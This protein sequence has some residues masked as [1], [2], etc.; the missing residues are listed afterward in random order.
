MTIGVSGVDA[1]PHR[2]YAWFAVF[3]FFLAATLSY[4]DRLILNLMVD[5]IRADLHISDTGISLLQGVAFAALYACLGLPLGRYA[6][7]HNRRNLVIAGVAVWSICT[8]LCGLAQSFGQ[9]FLVRVGVG[10]GEAALAPAAISMIADYFPPHR[11]GTAISLFLAGMVAGAGAANIIGG[12]LL[13][14]IGDGLL[15]H[16][17]GLAG[18]APWRAVFLILSVPGLLI[19]ALML[20]VREPR[21]RDRLSDAGAASI[22]TVVDY[23]RL[24]RRTFGL[25]L[26]AFALLQVVDY[27]INSWFPAHLMRRFAWTPVEV[28]TTLGVIGISCGL[29]GALAGG[30]LVDFVQSRGYIDAKVRVVTI[31]TTL[32]LPALLFPLLP[33]ATSAIALFVGYTLVMS[34]MGAAGIGAVQD[35]APSDMRGL[36]V[37]L[38]AFIY[39]LLGLGAGPT[40]VALT[41]DHILRD[42]AKVGVSIVLVA[43]PAAAIAAAL[44][45]N[46]LPSFRATRARMEA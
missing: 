30:V 42:P 12:A 16:V 39:T 11:R 23:L 45:W 29:I 36:M 1:Y 38:Q 26:T 37:S 2:A 7:R 4:T 33:T 10:I 27:A 31:A 35:V 22:A 41:T 18:I 15:A 19:I 5:A 8:A 20:F 13:G 40:L 14:A 32:L 6:D 43:M 44:L 34:M 25:M 17:P 28:G 21:R 46:L 3:V 24:N 9:M